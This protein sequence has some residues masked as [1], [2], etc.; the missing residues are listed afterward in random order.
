[1]L[2]SISKSKVDFGCI[3]LSP[4]FPGIFSSLQRIRWIMCITSLSDMKKDT[5]ILMVIEGHWYFQ[6]N[7]QYNMEEQ[8]KDHWCGGRGI[9]GR[10]GGRSNNQSPSVIVVLVCTICGF[11]PQ[12]SVSV[13]KSISNYL[14]LSY[15]PPYLTSF[16][17]LYMS[18]LFLCCHCS[19]CPCPNYQYI[20]HILIFPCCNTSRHL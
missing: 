19:C 18:L 6:I 2:T 17:P 11:H 13:S 9:G 20:L 5:E 4:P 10:I 7:I 14:F 15:L 8:R 12:N 3:F 16:Q 1:M